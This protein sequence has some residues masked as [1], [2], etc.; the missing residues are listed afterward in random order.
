MLQVCRFRA[1][2]C[3]RHAFSF[4]PKRIPIKCLTVARCQSKSQP[5][6]APYAFQCSWHFPSPDLLGL[7]RISRARDRRRRF[8]QS[9]RGDGDGDGDGTGSGLLS[10][11]DADLPRLAGRAPFVTAIVAG[12][13]AIHFDPSST[14]LVAIPHPNPDG[15]PLLVES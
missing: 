7:P 14:T 6:P 5:S 3:F 10:H 9:S 8:V 13:S 4:I 2:V 1:A 11:P 12:S 15:L